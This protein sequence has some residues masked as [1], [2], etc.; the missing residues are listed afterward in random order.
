MDVSGMT[1]EGFFLA[2]Y[3]RLR[4]ENEELKTKLG[5]A[6]PSG[7]GVFDLGHPTDAVKV[8]VNVVP[9][10]IESYDVTLD[11]LT[12]AS[13]MND[14]ELW[15]W[16]NAEY[17]HKERWYSPYKPIRVEYHRFQ[18]TLR[19]VET[20]YDRVFVTDGN[21]DDDCK[22]IRL[23]VWEGEECLGVWQD[24][25][26]FDHIKQEALTMLRYHLDMA[27]ERMQKEQ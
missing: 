20:R 10:S 25:G 27:I 7:F 16:G 3:E 22:I 21:D 4:K 17:K 18:Y 2:D 9:S 1:L 24:E 8:S 14:G 12:E 13:K 23:K 11:D 5:A 15:L 26:R 19:I 6:T